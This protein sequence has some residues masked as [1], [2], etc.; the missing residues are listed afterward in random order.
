MAIRHGGVQAHTV[1]DLSGQD[2]KICSQKFY[3]RGQRWQLVAHRRSPMEW[4]KL[5]V[6]VDDIGQAP[7]VEDL[8]Q[9][10]GVGHDREC[11]GEVDN[12]V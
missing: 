5:A 1:W 12:A 9:S 6:V 3:R 10:E 2:L 4:T 7:K 8:A 11:V